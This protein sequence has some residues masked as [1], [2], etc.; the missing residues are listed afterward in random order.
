MKLNDKS[1]T[2]ETG[3]WSSLITPGASENE[4]RGLITHASWYSANL[5]AVVDN[6]RRYHVRH[7][8]QKA[9]LNTEAGRQMQ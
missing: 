1:I 2:S 6:V 4:R 3:T 8:L 5:P 7:D 9:K